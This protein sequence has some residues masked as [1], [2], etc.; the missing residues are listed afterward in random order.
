MPQVDIDFSKVL[1]SSD[2]ETDK[3]FCVRKLT[4]TIP[5]GDTTSNTDFV[6]YTTVIGHSPKPDDAIAVRYQVY[7]KNSNAWQPASNINA[8]AAINGVSVYAQGTAFGMMVFAF[9]SGSTGAARDIDVMVLYMPAVKQKYTNGREFT[10]R[11]G[12]IVPINE[13]NPLK[14]KWS[15][16]DRQATINN[17]SIVR[18]NRSGSSRTVATIPHGMSSRPTVRYSTH[19]IFRP[20]GPSG[21]EYWADDFS[22]I[23]VRKDNTNIYVD[24]DNLDNDSS[25]VGVQLWW[26]NE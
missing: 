24:Y 4:L 2:R 25:N 18:F 19:I 10:M 23:Y 3:I 26:Y 21:E 8:A 13:G 22:R 16:F 9:A 5:A 11:T 6:G 12:P 17:T 15:S 14:I 7:F 20:N 1:W